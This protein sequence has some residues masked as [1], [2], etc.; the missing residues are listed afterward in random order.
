VERPRYF[1]DFVVGATFDLGER[2]VGQAEM[3]AFAREFDP[4]SYHTD[5]DL[6]RS[7]I[8]GGL[9]A[10]G[11]FTVGIYMRLLVDAILG[12]AASLASPGV[13]QVRW[14]RPV[15][16]GDRLRARLTVLETRLLA[17]R[18]DR[19]LVRTRGELLNQDGEV[20]LSLEA[21]NFLGRR[22]AA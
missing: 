9:V 13:E 6:A 5:P 14:P 10:S 16:P 18:P 1:E 20:V 3:I 12:Q 2:E 21:V 15:R 19:G 22:P 11:W 17:S 8:F 4:Q 7:S